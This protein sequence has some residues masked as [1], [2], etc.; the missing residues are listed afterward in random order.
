MTRHSPEAEEY[1]RIAAKL[2][3]Q[4]SSGGGVVEYTFN[5]KR[6]RKESIKDLI[7]GAIE[8]DRQADLLEGYYG[9]DL[10]PTRLIWRR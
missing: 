8:C 10:S 4:A 2:R 5:G 1:R 7:S 3:A 6:I 9:A